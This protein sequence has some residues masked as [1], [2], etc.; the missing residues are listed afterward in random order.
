VPTVTI[1]NSHEI[2]L[3]TPGGNPITDAF[4]TVERFPNF[5]SAVPEIDSNPQI[6]VFD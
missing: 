2:T 6:F 3:L 1:V 4:V 5:P